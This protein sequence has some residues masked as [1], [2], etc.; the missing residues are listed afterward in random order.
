MAMFK[1]IEHGFEDKQG[2]HSRE[3]T[4]QVGIERSD[5]AL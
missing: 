1:E 3:R 2:D 4:L 5:A